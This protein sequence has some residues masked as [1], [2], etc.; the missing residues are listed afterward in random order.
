MTIFEDDADY[1]AFE[2]VLAEAHEHVRMRTICY[3]LMPNHF[4]LTLWP[5]RDED[6][7]AFMHWLTMTHTQRWHANRRT[8]GSGHVYQGRFRSFPV[9][10]ADTAGHFWTVCRYVERNA[11]RAGLV[12]RAED[13]PW[14]SLH[15]RW[16]ADREPA[17]PL[18]DGP[19][20]WPTTWLELVNQPQTEEELA[21]L[22]RCGERGRPYGR[23]AWVK[24]T[25]RRLG[26][27][28]AL[29]PR[30][31]PPKGRRQGPQEPHTRRGTGS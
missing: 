5:R 16:V 30:G 18:A 8:T 27:L 21:A 4:H 28:T 31:R 1:L 26:L 29:H 11:L 13:W 15:R 6:L 2:R 10:S 9:D 17:L 7:S 23:D 3:C 19:P 12:A 24:R 22:R 14:S 20:P 25:A